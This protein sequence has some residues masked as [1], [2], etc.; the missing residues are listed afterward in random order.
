MMASSVRYQS[1]PPGAPPNWI[2]SSSLVAV[3]TLSPSPVYHPRVHERL[4][5]GQQRARKSPKRWYDQVGEALE[6]LHPV[7]DTEGRVARPEAQ[8][9]VFNPGSF[10]LSKV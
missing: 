9:D 3:V 6:L 4:A 7:V 5:R 8:R 1:S 10:K 2:M